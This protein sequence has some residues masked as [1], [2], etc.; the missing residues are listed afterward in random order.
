MRAVV[1]SSSDDIPDEEVNGLENPNILSEQA[2]LNQQEA[3][4]LEAAAYSKR[5]PLEKG[6]LLMSIPLQNVEE[7]TEVTGEEEQEPLTFAQQIALADDKVLFQARGNGKAEAWCSGAPRIPGSAT[8]GG[9]SKGKAA[10]GASQQAGDKGK[11]KFQ[12]KAPRSLPARETEAKKAAAG[13]KRKAPEGPAPTSKRDPKKPHR[14]RPGTLALR[15]IRKYQKSTEPVVPGSRSVGS[16]QS[17]AL[18]AL[19]EASQD[20]TVGLFGDAIFCVAHGKRRTLQAKDLDLARRI[21][22][23]RDDDN[24]RMPLQ[25]EVEHGRSYD[26]REYYPDLPAG[27]ERWKPPKQI[28]RE[29]REAR[30]RERAAAQEAAQGGAETFKAAEERGKQAGEARQIDSAPPPEFFNVKIDVSATLAANA[31]DLDG[32]SVYSQLYSAWRRAW[33]GELTPDGRVAIGVMV[34][35][36]EGPRRKA[37]RSAGG[38]DDGDRW[39]LRLRNIHELFLKGTARRGQGVLNG[40]PADSRWG[41]GQEGRTAF[42]ED[43]ILYVLNARMEQEEWVSPPLHV[44]DWKTQRKQWS[45]EGLSEAAHQE[46]EVETVVAMLR[47]LP[48]FVLEGLGPYYSATQ[49]KYATGTNSHVLTLYRFTRDAKRLGGR[50]REKGEPEFDGFELK[51]GL[52]LAGKADGRAA[53]PQ[54]ASG[55]WVRSRGTPRKAGETQASRRK[56]KRAQ[57]SGSLEEEEADDGEGDNGERLESDYES[58][59]DAKSVDLEADD[60]EM[61]PRF[62]NKKEGRDT[63]GPVPVRGLGDMGRGFWQDFE[64]PDELVM[65]QTNYN[66]ELAEKFLARNNLWKASMVSRILPVVVQFNTPAEEVFFAEA[67]IRTAFPGLQDHGRSLHMQALQVANGAPLEA[68]DHGTSEQLA[69]IAWRRREERDTSETDNGLML[70]EAEREW[71][72]KRLEDQAL[73]GERA[74][75]E[76]A[77]AAIDYKPRGRRGGRVVV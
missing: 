69:R 77:A 8:T 35:F 19:L 13:N 39:R 15:E 4:D 23:I 66:P 46:M 42:L 25:R 67:V 76:I 63:Y 18:D 17:S 74:E 43:A 72:R 37:I 38:E 34:D 60:D 36:L 68:T 52:P 32:S 65:L 16:W 55:D 40:A 53:G 51:G 9:N 58:E 22:V 24:N 71:K 7:V 27:A 70:T 1:R 73:L 62:L 33:Q 26:K 28:E 30:E 45:N 49:L 64:I 44:I 48:V 61:V 21:R 5:S 14:Y 56:E 31:A 11:N 6:P 47:K 12:S 41:A 50:D 10:E 59:D 2:N 75:H 3:E 54:P 29:E 20:F 57:K